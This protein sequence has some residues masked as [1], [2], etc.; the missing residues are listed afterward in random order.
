[1]P[2]IGIGAGVGTDGQ[3]LVLHD[4]WGV[5]TGQTPRF[6]RRYVDGER[7]A[8]RRPQPSRRRREGCAVPRG[9]RRA[10]RDERLRGP[11]RR[12]A[13]E[14]RHPDPDRADARFRPD[15]GRA[16]RGTSV[17]GAAKPWRRTIGRS[18][19]S[20]STRRSS[21]TRPIWRS[22]HGRWKPISTLLRA[23]GTDFV[24]LPSDAQL[25]TRMATAIAS[26]STALSTVLE[27][28][29]RARP[30]RR[31]PDRRPEAPADRLGRSRVL[32]REGLAAAEPR[33]R[34]GRRVLPAD[35]DCRVRDRPRRRWSGP[36]LTEPAAWSRSSATRRAQF[37]QALVIGADRRRGAPRSAGG[38]LC[39][40][41]R[42]GPRRPPA[43]RGAARR[44]AAHRQRAFGG[45]P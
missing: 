16:A 19:A 8:H 9:T 37:Y 6:V 23:E 18:S 44:C 39:R 28:T 26:P 38:G 20:S 41:L 13:I 4:L 22:I 40:R 35:R 24:L 7:P 1:M 14:R 3:V 5:D 29:H 10:T 27:G 21:T 32:R 42:R 12:G 25:C 11:V 31:R 36:Q 45:R 33:P 15:D 2:T 34:D 30:L 17:A 43:G